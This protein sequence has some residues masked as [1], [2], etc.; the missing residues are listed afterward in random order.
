MRSYKSIFVAI[1]LCSVGCSQSGTQKIVWREELA[2][3]RSWNSQDCIQPNAEEIKSIELAVRV[4]EAN[5]PSGRF[6]W[7]DIGARQTLGGM[8]ELCVDQSYYQRVGVALARQGDLGKH[9]LAEYELL[10]VS[11]IVN[12]PEVLI[13]DIARVAFSEMPWQSNI[14]VDLD[15]RPLARAIL[16][17]LGHQTKRFADQAFT[18]MDRR[19]ASGT[20]ASQI[21]VAAGHPLA[22]EKT[23]RLI[24]DAL[25]D[26]PAGQ[27][28]PWH[29]RNRLYELVLALTYSSEKTPDR[30]AAIEKIMLKKVQSNATMLGMVDLSPKK[31]CAMMPKISPNYDLKKFSYC[32]SDQPYEQ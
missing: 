17:T 13:N 28:I 8:N 12:P 23:L 14:F 29:T 27:S 16:A 25:V 31:M 4:I 21:A 30:V 19:T 9:K 24:D 5:D 6:G 18:L 3:T 2:L 7:L 1:V 11:K 32:F 15:I 20:G 10:L 26:I 22:L